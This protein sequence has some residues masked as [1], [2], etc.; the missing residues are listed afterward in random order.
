M[1]YFARRFWYLCLVFLVCYLSAFAQVSANEIRDVKINPASFNPSIGQKVKISLNLSCNGLL[2]LEIV[3]R[4]KYLVRTLTRNDPRAGQHEFSWDGTSESEIVPDEAYSL[5]IAQRC[6]S[7]ESLYFPAAR[8]PKELNVEFASYDSLNALLRY[9]LPAASRVQ[10]QAGAG[11]LDPETKKPRGPVM[12]VPV[13]HEPRVAGKIME[14]W[15]GMA[16][17]DSSIFIP[18]LPNFAFSIFA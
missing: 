3:D 8:L 6:G 13:N 15:N 12:K 2:T 5:R 9:T 16:E 4:D 14:Q 1:K 10:I 7:N 17:G 11:P 18:D